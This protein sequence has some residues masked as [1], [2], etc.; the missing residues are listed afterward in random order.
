M[1]R[2][3]LIKHYKFILVDVITN[4]FKKTS[5][6]RKNKF[7]TEFYLDYIFRILFFGEF[8]NTF[9]CPSCDRSTIRKKFYLWIQHDIF[10]IA[11]KIFAEKYHKNKTFKHL[12]IDS[13]IIQNI[14][15]SNEKID[16]YYKVISKK[17]TKLHVIVDSNKI[18]VTWTF[19]NPKNHD[20]KIGEEMIKKLDVNLKRKSYVVGDKGYVTRNKKIKTKTKTITV[21]YPMRINQ[22]KQNTEFEQ[23][24]LK[25]RYKVE[26]CF[27]TLK[28]TYKRLRFIYDRKFRNYETFMIMATTCMLISQ[29]YK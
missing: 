1:K 9:Y 13:S 3:T 25:S 17:Q 8:W 15:G 28:N 5:C 26:A 14:N 7:K 19:T 27:A 21:I 6:G 24:M 11:Y 23:N 29:I 20:M 12:Y 10:N 2:K 18:P 4:V 16:Y 22:K